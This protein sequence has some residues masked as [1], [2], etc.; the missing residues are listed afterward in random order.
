M[1]VNV[2]YAGRASA[3]RGAALEAADEDRGR[4]DFFVSHSTADLAWANWILGTLE[5][6]GYSTF[7]STRDVRAGQVVGEELE[8]ALFRADRMLAVLSPSYL[9]SKGMQEALLMLKRGESRIAP[10]RVR[11]CAPEGPLGDLQYLDLVGL[12][13]EQARARLLRE[14]PPKGQGPANASPWP[15]RAAQRPRQPSREAGPREESVHVHSVPDVATE[16]DTLGFEPYVAALAAFLSDENTR[17]P[18]TVSIEGAW[19]AGKSS[20]MRQLSNKLSGHGKIVHFSAWL[21]DKDESVW[22]S[23]ALDFVRSVRAQI[24][25]RKERLWS[26][27]KLATLRF[28]WGQAGS[29]FRVEALAAGLTLLLSLGLLA[30]LGVRVAVG[31][32]LPAFLPPLPAAGDSLLDSVLSSVA[33]GAS[34]LVLVAASAWAYAKVAVNP[35]E[36]ALAAGLDSPGY[37]A[38][39]SFAAQFH[40]DFGKVVDAYVGPGESGARVYVL[41]DDLDRCD[42]PR[43]AEVMQAI[44]LMI[45]ADPRLVFILGMD[46]EKVAAGLAVKHQELLPYL[47]STLGEEGDGGG[48]NGRRDVGINYGYD[49]I[50]KFVQVPFRIP[51]PSQEHLRT[52]IAALTAPKAKRT[53]RGARPQARPSLRTITIDPDA[54]DPSS[55]ATGAE[56]GAQPEPTREGEASQGRIEAVRVT[57]GLDSPVVAEMLEMVAPALDYNPRRL[58]QFLNLFRLRL[59]IAGATDMF[60]QEASRNALTPEQIAKFVAIS[61]RWPL[62]VAELEDAPHLLADLEHQAVEGAPPADM[63]EPQFRERKRRFQRW[64]ARTDVLAFL[65]LGCEPSAWRRT[66]PVTFGLQGAPVEA[67][68]RTSARV[69]A[70]PA[71]AVKEAPARRERHEMQVRE[72]SWQGMRVLEYSAPAK[73]RNRGAAYVSAY[74]PVTKEDVL[75]VE[76]LAAGP[77]EY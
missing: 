58:K 42:V 19:G 41:V 59:Y 44:N 1:R 69:A 36:K 45:G 77:D 11:E 46:R 68:L 38:R 53:P 21:H 34:G 50:E 64:A 74:V 56:G 16:T 55:A 5:E 73:S 76:T 26:D 37:G 20:F 75:R 65:R 33:W 4:I 8:A 25:S 10:I 71:R 60:H 47:S 2:Y 3:R 7:I 30:V 67:L 27:L 9:S 51:Q 6:A 15:G 48:T 61:I 28:K 14:F 49:F 31:A 40:E 22:A 29:A 52:F 63:E 39:I 13:E 57:Y 62:L 66:D 72:E 23:F 70:R 24:P 17:P 54:A 43:A 12:S 18:L 32:P 35:V